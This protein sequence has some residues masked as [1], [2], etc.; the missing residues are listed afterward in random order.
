MG[1]IKRVVDMQ[2]RS[3]RPYGASSQSNGRASISTDIAKDV[4]HAPTLHTAVST[5]F[6]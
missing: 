4:R 5:H 3:K 1:S 6:K 2:E